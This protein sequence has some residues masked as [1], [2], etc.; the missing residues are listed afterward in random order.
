[1][2]KV[3]GIAIEKKKELVEL[4]EADPY[5]KGSFAMMG[6]KLKEGNQVGA[7]EKML[8][9]Y[10]SGD[11]EKIKGA[12]EK[13]KELS[14]EVPADIEEK[15]IAVITEEEDKAATGMGDIFG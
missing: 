2:K 10:L 1:M 6:Y 4:L 7:D 5:A 3:F 8:Y 12:G 15:V 11:D 13:L 14:V 9:L